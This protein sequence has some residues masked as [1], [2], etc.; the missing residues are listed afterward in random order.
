MDGTKQAALHHVS[1]ERTTLLI[2]GKLRLFMDLNIPKFDE[3]LLTGHSERKPAALD[4]QKGS[5][6]VGRKAPNLEASRIVPSVNER[7]S[8]RDAPTILLWAVHVNDQ[9]DNKIFLPSMAAKTI[10]LHPDYS[11]VKPF[12]RGERISFTSINMKMTLHKVGDMF[13]PI[14]PT[15]C[16]YP[17]DVI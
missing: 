11:F 16:S 5:A 7:K 13:N 15:E 17:Q 8:L 9:T 12:N 3:Q 1:E 2:P 6:E 10:H 14:L 4:K